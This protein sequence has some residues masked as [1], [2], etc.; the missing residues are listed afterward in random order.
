MYQKPKNVTKNGRFKVARDALG[1]LLF[2]IVRLQTKDRLAL[3]SCT[4]LKNNKECNCQK[5]D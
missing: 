1:K 5:F 4:A 3:L 2:Q